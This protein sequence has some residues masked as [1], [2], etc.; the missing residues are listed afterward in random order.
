MLV[1]VFLRSDSRS[2]LIDLARF[3]HLRFNLYISVGISINLW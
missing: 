2:S 3:S 1:P